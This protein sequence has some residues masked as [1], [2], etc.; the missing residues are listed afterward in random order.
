MVSRRGLI[1]SC[2]PDYKETLGR[3]K[4]EPGLRTVSARISALRLLGIKFPTKRGRTRRVKT[5]LG[6]IRF[7]G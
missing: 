1:L 2:C 3:N 7:W 4:F 5:V 6:G